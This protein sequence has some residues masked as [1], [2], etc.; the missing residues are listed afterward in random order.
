MGWVWLLRLVCTDGTRFM[1][2]IELGQVGWGGPSIGVARAVGEKRVE[3]GSPAPLWHDAQPL[4]TPLGERL[5]ERTRGVRR[6]LF[7]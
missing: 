3:E 7:P 4:R 1:G 2:S 6:L 5:L